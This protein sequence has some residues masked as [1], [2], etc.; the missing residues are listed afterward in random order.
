VSNVP[1][2][3]KSP[4]AERLRRGGTVAWAVMGM[5]AVV[6]LFGL[7]LWT[8]RV[9]LPPLILAGA[10]VFL[11]NPAVT[12]M[13]RRGLHRALGT[14]VAYLSVLGVIALLALLVIPLATD[15]ANQLS[16]TWPDI[17]RRSEN[18]VEDLSQRSDGT[19]FEFTPEELTSALNGD[20]TSLAEQLD[21][22]RKIGVQLFHVL[23][24]VVLAPIIA[25]YLLVDLPNISAV[26]RGLVPERA[27]YEVEIVMRRLARAIGGFFRGQLVVAL[28]V[29]VMVSVGLAIIGLKF[30][31]LVGMIAGFFNMIPL[32]GPW[33]GGIPGVVIALTT[34]DTLQAV[35]VVVVMVIAQ[36]IDNH[37][38]TP[39]V[40][41]RAVSLHPAAVVLALLAGGSL[42]GFFGLLLAVPTAAALKILCGHLW[43]THILGEAVPLGVL[44]ITDESEVP[45][46]GEDI[47][48]APPSAFTPTDAGTAEMSSSGSQ[49]P[50]D[51][52]TP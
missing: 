50:E 37:F 6:A 2:A 38:I 42:G 48:E 19:F 18:F 43:R 41:Q 26:A 17:E 49:L 27:R 11:L 12:G 23:L 3:P 39:Q 31:F 8:F 20:G 13:A 45:A 34:G 32:I 30:W 44:E 46:A 36:Q 35:G 7:V 4:V 28:V 29:G 47:A 51:G 10:I 22:I 40:M 14:A 15:Q 52:K 5:A 25:F 21:R 33:V 24:I 16:E 1:V 9:I